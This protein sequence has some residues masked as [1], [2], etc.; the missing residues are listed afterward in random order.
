MRR[1]DKEITVPSAIE[2]IMVEAQVCR[3][4][5]VDGDK[6]YMVPLSFGLK[7]DCLYFHSSP[8]G[9]KIDL[10]T[11]NPNVCFEM[12]LPGELIEG[13]NPCKWGVQYRSVIGFGT[14]EFLDDPAEKIE[15]LHTIMAHYTARSFSF[16]EEMVKNVALIKLRIAEVYA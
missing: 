8:K 3:L 9:M 5:M 12:D 1:K 4:A 15:A 7:G 6:P 11:A 2:E 14:V 16:T 10:L 13:D